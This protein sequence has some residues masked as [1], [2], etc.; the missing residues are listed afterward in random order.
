[1]TPC[2]EEDPP[3]P[4]SPY[5]DSKLMVEMML[6]SYHQAYGL[7]FVT[8]RYFNACGA[9]RL[10]RHGQ[11]PNATHIIARVLE[12]ARNNEPFVLY[13][14]SYPTPD[15]TC[16]RDYVHVEDIARAHI[17]AIDRSIPIDAYNLGSNNGSSNRDI[18]ALAREITNKDIQVIEDQ[19]RSGDPAELTASA[20]KFSLLAQDWRQHSLRDMITHAWAWYNK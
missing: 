7:D 2:Q 5:G 18:I 12:S 3:M 14:T 6:K 17:L 9:D 4:I 1:M 10:G 20:A 19:P 16:I 8:F 15:G 13:G 11:R